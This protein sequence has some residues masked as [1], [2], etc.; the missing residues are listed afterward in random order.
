MEKGNCR[1]CN[2]PVL[3]IRMAA[4]G[5]M[6]PLDLEPCED[7]TVAIVDG[8]GITKKS[9]LFEAMI[10][11]PFYKSHFATCPQSEMHRKKKLK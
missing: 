1:S 10:E 2:A 11:G 8:Q 3:W 7:G 4:S 6:M 5:A 9:N